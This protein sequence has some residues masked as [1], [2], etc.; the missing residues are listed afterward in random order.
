[1]NLFKI[2][3]LTFLLFAASALKSQGKANTSAAADKGKPETK[4][5][6]VITTDSLPSSEILAR[7]VNW[8]KLETPKYEKSNGVTTAGKAECIVKFSIKPKELNPPCDYT[9]HLTMKVVIEAKESR[10]RYT[11]NQIKHV[12]KSGKTSGGNIDN[13]VPE[14]GSMTMNDT[15]WKKL[16]GEAIKNAMVVVGDLKEAMKKD[17]KAVGDE[18]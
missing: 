4:F 9:G 10:Y 3:T 18:W 11:V 14:C 12:S 17:S 1:M 2:G 15:Q 5:T 7:A 6:E 16:K 13:V 8:V